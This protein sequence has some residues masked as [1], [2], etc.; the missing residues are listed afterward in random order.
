MKKLTL[1][2]LAGIVFVGAAT[3]VARQATSLA[4]P[5][6]K[7]LA[8]A[9][10]DS[11]DVT[12]F[13]TRGPVTARVRRAW[14]PR[15]ADRAFHAVRARYYDGVRFYRVIP[16]FMAQFGFN[17]EPAIT[18]AWD[19]FPMPDEPVL[20]PNV[21]GAVTFASRG[22]NTRTV[23]LF[24]NTATNANLDQ[25]GFTPIGEVLNGMGSV[26]SLYSGYGEGAPNGK[27]PDQGMMAGAGNKY[28]QKSFPRLD[29]ID[30]ARVVQSW[31]AGK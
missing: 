17:G 3:L 21:R 12:F 22:R 18:R 10:P 20:H 1:G 5:T 7:G 23:Q 28:L 27:G 6:A 11:F 26:D 4:M 19:A 8:V 24:I 16:G 9:G 31:K 25:L 2:L 15:G 30:S 29:S 14:A 13:T